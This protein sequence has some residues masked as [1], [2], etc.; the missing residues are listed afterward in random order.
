MKP[1]N[2]QTLVQH[3]FN[4]KRKY[5]IIEVVEAW[6]TLLDTCREDFYT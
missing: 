5:E 1:G 3:F 2:K 4:I 6:E